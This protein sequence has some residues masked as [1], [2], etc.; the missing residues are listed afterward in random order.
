VRRIDTNGW[1][2]QHL[3]VQRFSY[4][5]SPSLFEQSGL[6]ILT[7]RHGKSATS[8]PFIMDKV[9][10]SMTETLKSRVSTNLRTTLYITGEA[11]EAILLETAMGSP[12]PISRTTSSSGTFKF[13]EDFAFH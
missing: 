8:A 11:E 4:L 9:Y 1:R 10:R 5:L 12:T 3:Y 7:T 2:S 6:C 13:I